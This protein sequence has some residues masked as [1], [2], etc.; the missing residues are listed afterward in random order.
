MADQS[1][2][3]IADALN[4]MTPADSAFAVTPNDDDD[5]SVVTRGVFIGGAGNLKVTLSSGDTVTFTDIAK[6]FVHPIR[7][8][9][10]F[11]TGTTATNILGL[12]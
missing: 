1:Y 4:A 9:R 10:I 6:G 12:Y 11:S 7:A 2:G 3:N 8:K 5:L